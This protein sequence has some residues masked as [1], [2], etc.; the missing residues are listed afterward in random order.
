MSLRAD[1]SQ[2]VADSLVASL[3]A[4]L[5]ARGSLIPTSGTHGASIGGNDV[6]AGDEDKEFR[7]LV[8]TEP[9]GGTIA[10]DEDGS[11]VASGFEDGA[12]SGTYR[13]FVDG[14]EYVESASYVL[15]VGE[16]EETESGVM[17]LA[18]QQNGLYTGIA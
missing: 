5:G 17:L 16:F 18:M 13:G 15:E 12:H 9:D 10:F 4:G 6:Q 11:F 1:T 14:V 2:L 3:Y 8:I 7:F